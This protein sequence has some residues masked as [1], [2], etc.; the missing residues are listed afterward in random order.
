[1]SP[2]VKASKIVVG[3]TFSRK[4]VTLCCSAALAYCSTDLASS[5]ETSTF[6]PAPGL[7]T[8]TITS[9]TI[10][11]SVLTTSKYSE[12]EHAGLADRLHVLH[13]GDAGHDGAEDDRRDHHLDELDEAVAERL[14]RRRRVRH[15]VAEQYADR[16][17]D[18][19]L[20]IE[21]LVERSGRRGGCLH[22]TGLGFLF[23]AGPRLARGV[24]L[25]P[26]LQRCP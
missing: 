4:S 23:C 26:D 6:M 1:M 3:I 18:E 15:E 7:T 19:D 11:A 14:E 22:G 12:R 13:A 5:V 24:G 25:K 20:E 17:G 10:S 9:P 21:R 2:L 8:L 16:D